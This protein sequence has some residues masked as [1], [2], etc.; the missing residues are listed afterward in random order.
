ME[1]FETNSCC[2]SSPRSTKT[3]PSSSVSK[4]EKNS[5]LCLGGEDSRA[6]AISDDDNFFKIIEEDLKE[7]ILQ[8]HCYLVTNISFIK[9]KMVD[10]VALIVFMELFG[11]NK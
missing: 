10:T 5:F 2:I 3:S 1:I 9:K 6:C 7:H 8:C 11:I 4:S